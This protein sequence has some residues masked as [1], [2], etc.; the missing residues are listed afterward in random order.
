[1]ATTNMD[2]LSNVEGNFMKLNF[3]FLT[4]FLSLISIA[5]QAKSI[6]INDKSL[7]SKDASWEASLNDGGFKIING[8]SNTILV[9]IKLDR[10]VIGVYSQ[11]GSVISCN[12]NLSA[13]KQPQVGLC[14]IQ[15]Q[16]TLNVDLDYAWASSHIPLT[17]LGTYEII[18]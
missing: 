16:S 1:M 10:G 11:D 9:R 4:I 12:L 17:A 15:P 3:V 5:A 8:T 2:I 14:E 13:E 6:I 18:S 7:I